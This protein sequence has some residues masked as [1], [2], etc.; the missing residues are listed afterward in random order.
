VEGERDAR[1][2]GGGLKD[3]PGVRSEWPPLFTVRDGC[4]CFLV[5]FGDAVSFCLGSRVVHVERLG[6]DSGRE[7]GWDDMAGARC[8]RFARLSV[9]PAGPAA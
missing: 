4:V 6:S 7:A 5:G 9:H 2:E 1:A 3:R 8:V